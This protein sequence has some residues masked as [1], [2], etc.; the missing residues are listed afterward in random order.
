MISMRVYDYFKGYYFKGFNGRLFLK[1][2][3]GFK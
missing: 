3:V 1:V 2:I